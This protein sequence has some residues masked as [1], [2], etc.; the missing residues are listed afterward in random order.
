MT[1]DAEQTAEL[2]HSFLNVLK[3]SFERSRTKN[4]DRADTPM[5][6]GLLS[7]SRSG[8]GKSAFLKSLFEQ[9]NEKVQFSK[10]G[11]EAWMNSYAQ[12]KEGAFQ[13]RAYDYCRKLNSLPPRELQGID[14]SE[15]FSFYAKLPQVENKSENIPFLIN[16]QKNI[17]FDLKNLEFNHARKIT[18]RT[19]EQHG[20]MPEFKAFLEQ[21]SHLRIQ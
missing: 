6:I 2:G 14:I 11:H 16:F 12:G 15:H 10:S 4:Y 3:A 8:V 9:T 1:S 17:K 21:V 18:L 19:D 13:I 5:L 7:N 20:T